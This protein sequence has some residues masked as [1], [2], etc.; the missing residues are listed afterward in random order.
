AAATARSDACWSSS[1]TWT[2]RTPVSRDTIGTR[3]TTPGFL[4]YRSRSA[5][6][7]SRTCSGRCT[8]TPARRA[9]GRGEG[10]DAATARA[11]A[12]DGATAGSGSTRLRVAVTR[13]ALPWCHA[14]APRLDAPP[15]PGRLAR[16]GP[17][18]SAGRSPPHRADRRSPRLHDVSATALAQQ[19]HLYTAHRTHP[20]GDGRVRRRQRDDRPARRAQPARTRRD[21]LD[22][23]DRRRRDLLRRR[24]RRPR[25]RGGLAGVGAPRPDR[26]A[27]QV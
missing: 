12:G 14:R 5:A 18:Q 21:R 24:R 27:A 10:R 6:A 7:T 3:G 25:D 22:D 13:F 8:A 1:A 16:G 4:R 26:E 2:V 9:T 20:P 23:D 11:E 19:R 17:G 15:A